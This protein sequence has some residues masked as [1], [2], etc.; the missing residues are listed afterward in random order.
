[1][2]HEWRSR[3]LR[4]G[5]RSEPARGLAREMRACKDAVVF[6][7]RPLE[8]CQDFD[9]LLFVC[10]KLLTNRIWEKC[11]QTW[12]KIT[13]GNFTFMDR[14]GSCDYAEKKSQTKLAFAVFKNLPSMLNMELEDLAIYLQ[15]IYLQCQTAMETVGKY[16]RRC[17]K[18]LVYQ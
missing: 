16:W 2:W 4:V 1:M 17:A 18:K 9:N 10:V 14:Y 3:E 5:E 7:F 8:R 12:Q 11:Q 6:P 15:K 13:R